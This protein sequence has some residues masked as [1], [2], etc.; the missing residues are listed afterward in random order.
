MASKYNLKTK[1]KLIK[2]NI[3]FIKI[4]IIKN[5]FKQNK[6][7]IKFLMDNSI[8]KMQKYIKINPTKKK[9]NKA[10]LLI[11][12]INHIHFQTKTF[13]TKMEIK[14]IT[15]ISLAKIF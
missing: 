6:Q 9:L 3:I 1:F 10:I 5:N 7:I 4:K 15:K 2:I 8:Y 14:I 11:K 13:K 12:I